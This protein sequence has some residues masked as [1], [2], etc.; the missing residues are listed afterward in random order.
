LKGR[1][2]IA[3]NRRDQDHVWGSAVVRFHESEAAQL[4]SA[5]MMPSHA[6]AIQTL[7]TERLSAYEAFISSRFFGPELPV[8]RKNSVRP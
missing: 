3:N 1:D 4:A 8:V 6:G 5:P 2:S 7:Y